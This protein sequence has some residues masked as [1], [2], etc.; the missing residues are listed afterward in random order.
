[1]NLVGHTVKYSPLNWLIILHI[2]TERCNLLHYCLLLCHW[3]A[4]HISHFKQ[5]HLIFKDA[6]VPSLKSDLLIIWF[7]F[8]NYTRHHAIT[9][10]CCMDSFFLFLVCGFTVKALYCFIRQKL[11][12]LKMTMVLTSL[13]MDLTYQEKEQVDAISMNVMVVKCLLPLWLAFKKQ[14]FSIIE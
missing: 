7:V 3:N 6:H 9:L 14:C 8:E 4:K 13:H 10:V 12:S 11:M 1:M 2:L 5:K